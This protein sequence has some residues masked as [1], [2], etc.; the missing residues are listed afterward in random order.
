MNYTLY[1]DS[2]GGFWLRWQM[3][4][5]AAW[6]HENLWCRERAAAEFAA[7]QFLGEPS[8]KLKFDERPRVAFEEGLKLRARKLRVG[9]QVERGFRKI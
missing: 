6:F 4:D 2:L 1:Q 8:A 9:H 5:G 3:P 7:R